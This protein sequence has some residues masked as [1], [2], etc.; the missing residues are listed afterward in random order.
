MAGDRISE[1]YEGKI[2]PNI[3]LDSQRRIHWFL[4][5]LYGENILDIGCS[6]GILPL[7][8]GREGKTVIGIDN[9]YEAISY[10]LNKLN[11]ESTE[12]KEF[13]KFVCADFLNYNFG[14]TKFDTIV[15]GEILEHLYNPTLFVEK[16]SH[17]IADNGRLI[18]SGPFGINRYFDHK[19]T[20][21]FLDL[22][23][24]LNVYFKVYD[25]CFLGKWIAMLVTTK[26]K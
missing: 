23:N 26:K 10:A 13:V 4:E 11:E 21:Y 2:N 7:L 9:D 19:K 6:Q 15:L 17:L 22:F 8:A 25:V 18:V 24:M 20:Y 5:N 16:A 1:A 3:Q 12:V 14:N